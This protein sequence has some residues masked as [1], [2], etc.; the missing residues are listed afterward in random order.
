MFLSRNISLLAT[1]LIAAACSSDA[2][3]EEQQTVD[4]RQP[5]VFGTSSATETERP[6]TRATSLE[7]T[8]QTFK[9]G[10]WKAF[11]LAGQQNVM[12]GY[13]VDYTDTQR[14]DY[15]DGYNW[16]YENVNGQP[17]RYWDLSAYPYEF[18]AV[19]PCLPGATIG[20]DGITITIDDA[21]SS[22][23]RAQTL[24]NNTYNYSATDSEPCVVANVS[25]TK[26]G[27]GYADTDKI[28]NAEINT[29][30]KANATREVHLPFHHLISKIGFRIFIDNPQPVRPEWQ[31]DYG[32]WIE[33]IT[34]TVQKP[35]GFITESKG[36]SATNAQGLQ[37][38][39]FTGN[40]TTTGE[41]I[42]LS[43]N[44]YGDTD[45]N[46]HN[47]LNQETA[48]DLS[49][50]CL[51]QLPQQDV[52]VRVQ[53]QIKTNHVEDDEQEFNYDSWLSLDPENTNGD[54]FTW[55]PENK[56]IYYLRIPNLHGHEI[57][58][59]TCEILPWDEVQTTDIGVGL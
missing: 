43:H 36:Y 53:M 16:Y 7:D 54:L 57:Y 33:N 2:T 11:G 23:F 45:Q 14:T 25:R 39:T 31:V 48:F 13:E 49:P 26:N 18:R 41:F 10:T 4:M 42:V 29:V 3:L 19:S 50:N 9:V 47:H 44:L 27:T 28:K 21:T 35:S 58:L 12:D 46:L 56:Y 59:H 20:A 37:H 22:P 38:G 6:V 34:I 32:V 17:L 51:H 52:K 1:A 55:E 15:G 24:T 30:G 40:T 5:M 8:Y